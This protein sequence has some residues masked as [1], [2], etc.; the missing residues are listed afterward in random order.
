MKKSV[1]AFLLVAVSASA[2]TVVANIPLSAN[3]L[4]VA[5]N[6]LSDRIYV[7][8]Q[9]FSTGTFELAVVDGSTNS[10]LT[11]VPLSTA[12]QVAVNLVTRRVYVAGCDFAQSICNVSVVDGNNNKL[13]TTIPIN[14]N[15]GIGLQGLA[16]N[17]VTNRIYVSDADNLLVDVIDG[18]TNQI[19]GSISLGGQQPLGLAVD[20]VR[21]RLV[22]VINGPLIAVI[23]GRD[24]SILQRVFVGGENFN[25]AVNPVLGR[26]YVT[27]NEFAPF[28]TLGVVNIDDF[29]VV[30]NITVGN[31]PFGVAADVVSGVVFVTNSFDQTISVIDGRKNQVV[32][33]VPASGQYIDVNPIRGLAYAGDNFL[34]TLHVISER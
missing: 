26:A 12:R 27:N 32:E 3:P 20:F 8:A 29:S 23:D 7:A 11:T 9:D 6:P 33:T 13:L 24:N 17:P 10:Q 16:V 5:V 15:P 21:N 25:V 30:T 14:H 28:A 34:P 1:L 19:M 18:G 22:A 31:D 2:Q 4:G